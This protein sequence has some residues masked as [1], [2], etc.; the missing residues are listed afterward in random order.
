MCSYSV[1]DWA[2]LHN[3]EFLC[4]QYTTIDAQYF[5]HITD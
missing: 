5:H 4:G 1:H 3:I 2:T